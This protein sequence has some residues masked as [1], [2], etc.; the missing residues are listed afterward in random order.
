MIYN[1]KSMDMDLN[2]VRE[3]AR[4]RLPS[5]QAAVAVLGYII[6]G[7]VVLLPY[8]MYVQDEETDSQEK[9]PYNAGSRILLLIL[10]LFPF[11]LGVYTINCMVV[12]GCQVWSWIVALATLLWAAIVIVSAI[13]YK[14]F[15]LSDMMV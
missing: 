9:R 11:A 8:D 3:I 5:M 7:V 2:T 6:L 10:L 1:N 13:T 4:R 14:S 15:R 12:G